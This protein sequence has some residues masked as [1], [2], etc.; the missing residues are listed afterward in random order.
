LYPKGKLK[1][2]RARIAAI[3]ALRELAAMPPREE[4]RARISLLG[5]ITIQL[6]GEESVRV[7]GAQLCTLLGLMAA[8]RML[9]KPL[10]PGELM[11]IVMGSDRDPD[12]ARKSMNFAVFR[13]REMLGSEAISTAGE[14]PGLNLDLV[15]IDLL[16]A[17]RHLRQAA[18]A[19]RH[20]ALLRAY[21]ELLAALEITAGKVPFP[22]LYGEFFESARE[23]F[24]NE[25]RSV[26]IR[27]AQALIRE[28][29]A[30]AAEQVLAHAFQAMPDDEDV[31]EL[32]QQVLRDLGKRAEAV[33]I[34]LKI[35]D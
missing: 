25:L 21:P 6:P 14:T 30:A 26:V 13:L 17:H 8:D 24:E 5:S 35:E 15:E 22:T 4:Q 16:D 20:G 23:D 27:V 29:D 11:S 18:A 31:A 10:T 9:A 2:W 1:S 32:L 7:R 33:R 12:S 3:A 19:L 34:G 28:G